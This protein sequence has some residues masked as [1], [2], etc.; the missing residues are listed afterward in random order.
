VKGESFAAAYRGAGRQDRVFAR[1]F[2]AAIKKGKFRDAPIILSVVTNARLRFHLA[3]WADG[4]AIESGH[5][6][7]A[8]T[9]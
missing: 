8:R 2:I 3:D 7:K 5:V 1:S 6:R 4:R 9:Q